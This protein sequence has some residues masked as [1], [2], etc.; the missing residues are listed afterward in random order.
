VAVHHVGDMDGP[1]R[2]L[3]LVHQNNLRPPTPP[4]AG[5]GPRTRRACRW[6]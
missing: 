4:A 6:V 1:Q 3:R 5:N 2:V